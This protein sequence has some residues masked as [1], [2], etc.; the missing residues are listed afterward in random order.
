[1]AASR[2]RQT[3][4][5]EKRMKSVLR[6]S[7]VL[8]ILLVGAMLAASAYGQCVPSA[9][10]QRQSWDGVGQFRTVDSGRDHDQDD[11]GIVGMWKVDFTAQGN[12]DVRFPDGA[13][14]DHAL[15]QWHSDGTE[16]MNSSRPPASQS[17]CLGVWKRVGH[18]HYKLNHFAISWD[19][20]NLQ[21]P[22]GPANIREDIKLAEDGQ[23]FTG[24][25]AITQ[26]DGSGNV[27]VRIVGVL[28]GKRIT[29]HSSITDVL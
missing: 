19:P 25:F 14:I 22:L 4:A 24:T 5:E 7:T 28:N 10:M 2:L 21:A 1:M 16:I 11:D 29:V 3:T 9:K 13:P 18:S 27:L 17:F 6:V 23:S 15:A 26:Y 20:N 8:G 12:N